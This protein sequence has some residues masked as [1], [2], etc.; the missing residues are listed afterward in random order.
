MHRPFFPFT[1]ITNWKYAEECFHNPKP[2][3]GTCFDGYD[4]P[5]DPDNDAN[6]T[7]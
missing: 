1:P 5:V 4:Y 6:E 3:T 2:G 7:D